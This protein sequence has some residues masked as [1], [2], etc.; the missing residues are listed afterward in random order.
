M[1]IVTSPERVCFAH[2]MEFWDGLMAYARERSSQAL[3]I[4]SM[5]PSPGDH[6]DRRLRLAS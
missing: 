5:G 4:A 6:E 3:A 2:A 1:K